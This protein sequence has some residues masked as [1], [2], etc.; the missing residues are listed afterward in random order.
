V[1]QFINLRTGESIKQK[2]ELKT[3][4]IDNLEAARQEEKKE[5][6]G[7]KQKKFRRLRRLRRF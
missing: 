6:H 4:G 2:T 5:C 7:E 1:D 3:H